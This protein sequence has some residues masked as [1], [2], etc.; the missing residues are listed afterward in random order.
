MFNKDVR[1][2]GDDTDG[3]CLT[4]RWVFSVGCVRGDRTSPTSP[5]WTV[6]GG[7]ERWFYEVRGVSF[8]NGD[9]VKVDAIS[10]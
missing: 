5:F 1:V 9:R 4:V 2:S 8:L 3:G 10:Y 7:E 6:E